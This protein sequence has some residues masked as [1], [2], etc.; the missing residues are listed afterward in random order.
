M[1]TVVLYINASDT[2]EISSPNYPGNYSDYIDK[3]WILHAEE[4]QKIY[5]TFSSFEADE[6]SAYFS[7]GDGDNIYSNQF[8]NWYRSNEPPD[9]IST[10]NQIW[11]RFSSYSIP[12][13]SG[14]V[15]SASSIP[16]TENLTCAASEFDCGHSVC[17]NGSWRCDKI[18]DCYDGSDEFSCDTTVL[19]I[20]VSDTLEISSPNYPSNSSDD[21]DK[22]WIL[23]AEENQKI[24][25]TF[26]SFEADEYSAYFSAGDGAN[27]YSNQFFEWHSYSRWNEPP[28]LISHANQI[29]LRFT[30]Y[31]SSVPSRFV[32][33]ATSIPST[34][35][36]TCAASEFDCGHS[37]CI[38]GSWRCDYQWD[39]YGGSD[40]LSCGNYA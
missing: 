30:S 12:A 4:N 38:N 15:L 36:L 31:W 7:A 1:H 34:E 9:L 21:I 13:T 2:L 29:W 20:N 18:Y 17:I 3:N 28:D 27:L 10:G 25:I 37:V 16:A 33:S 8:F 32:L 6:Y 19:Y 5:I 40:E 11:L 24:Y 22:T 26:S 35:N 23:H 14:F 39:C